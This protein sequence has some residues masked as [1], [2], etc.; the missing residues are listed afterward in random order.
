MRTRRDWDDRE[1][2]DV[3]DRFKSGQSYQVIADRYAVT[4][5]SIAGM[6]NRF[7]AMNPEP[8][9]CVKPENRDGGMPFGWWR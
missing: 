9:A 5:N 8:C 3:L 1:I 2:L 7:K 6:V 4:R